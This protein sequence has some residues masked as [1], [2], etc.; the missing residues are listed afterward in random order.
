VG[1]GITLD[2]KSYA[3]VGVIP[4]SFSFFSAGS[5]V[6]EVFVPI[7][8]WTNNMLAS[9]S[10]GLGI[11]GIGR[12]KPGVTVEQARADMANV[13]SNLAEA[14]PDAN[15][16][17]GAK[18]IP[19]KEWMV[20]G[21]ETLLLVLLAS[22]GFV[23]LI[24]CVN[25]ANL[26]LARSTGTREFA[27]RGAWVRPAPSSP[28]T[29]DGASCGFRRW[30]SGPGPGR[31]GNKSRTRCPSNRFAAFGRIGLDGRVLFFTLAIT[32]LRVLF[33]LAPALKMSLG[34]SSDGLKER[35]RH[36]RNRNHPAR[37]CG[38]GDGD[39]TR[40]ACRGRPD[41]QPNATVER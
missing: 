41:P 26:L 18:L 22:V 20:H 25:V 10:A 3:I 4:A 13:T 2:G 36:Q 34:N 30:H 28:T 17:T 1:K 23:L 31:M 16:G 21:V 19:L 7:G 27:I 38:C 32:R 24:A 5:L 33:G 37:V 12:L 9:R 40:A 35:P 15:K 39:G 6:R 8:Q 29:V 14:Y 11:N